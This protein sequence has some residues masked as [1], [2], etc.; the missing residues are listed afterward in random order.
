MRSKSWFVV[1]VALVLAAAGACAGENGGQTDSGSTATSEVAV[2]DDEPVAGGTLTIATHLEPPTF[3]FA[4]VRPNHR[5]GA[6]VQAIYGM[7]VGVDTETGEIVPGLAESVEPN[8][9][10]TQWTITLRDTEFTD[11]TPF[12]ANAVKANWDYMND[13][14]VASPC[15][16][17][18][19]G[20]ES[21]EAVDD[22]TLVVNLPAPRGGFV[23]Q[24][25][26]TCLGTIGSPTALA[27]HGADF[28]SSPETTVAAGPFILEEFVHGSHARLVRNPE[29]WDAPKPYVE[30]LV[31]QSGVAPPQAVDAVLG[32]DA[33]YAVLPLVTPDISR[34]EDAGMAI[35]ME[36]PPGGIAIRFNQQRPPLDDPRVREAFV[37]A[38]DLEEWNE[39]VTGGLGD[40]VD[41]YFPENSP[42][43]DDSVTQDVNDLD[44]AQ[45]LIDD[46]LADN[47]GTIELEMF[48]PTTVRS[49]V[50]VLHQQWS[51][52]EGVE[53]TMDL[54]DSATAG[55]RHASCDFDIGF[56]GSSASDPEGLRQAWH[57]TST[58]NFCKYSNPEM[59]A[60]LDELRPL[61]DPDEQRPV[62]TEFTQ[63]LFD[64]HLG[65]FHRRYQLPGV[66]DPS[67]LRGFELRTAYWYPDLASVWLAR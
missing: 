42:F 57:S 65:L 30:E 52:L 58:Q 39:R 66:Y 17:L 60:L 6:Y 26:S 33:D 19:A 9:D 7:L 67:S 16:T 15:L 5:D 20:F 44:Q 3:H 14:S 46:Y 10:E 25:A 41:T 13:P 56:G 48:T 54:V 35:S 45:S 64:E 37:L 50:E 11:G 23:A 29:Y 21:W 62:V 53:L 24:L 32:G 63:F 47:P 51:R 28:G 38:T 55:S 31:L 36:F 49:E 40:T 18:L 34:A 2:A 27:A 43:F 22:R 61:S 1:C 59:D 12:D 4:T 8:E